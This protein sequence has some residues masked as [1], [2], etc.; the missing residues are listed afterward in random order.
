MPVCPQFNVTEL[1]AAGKQADLETERLRLKAL[2]A[3]S[4]VE[5]AREK[6]PPSP[7]PPQAVSSERLNSLSLRFAVGKHVQEICRSL[8]FECLF[9]LLA[10]TVC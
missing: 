4:G 2:A 1:A 8:K 6:T 10:V 5:L 3:K 7:P 9:A